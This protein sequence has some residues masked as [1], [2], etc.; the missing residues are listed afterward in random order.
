MKL[1]TE[2]GAFILKPETVEDC[3]ELLHLFCFGVEKSNSLSQ[4]SRI[5]GTL[6]ICLDIF[7]KNLKQIRDSD[8]WQGDGI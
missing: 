4:A 1:D 8:I 7:R 6:M 3:D 2:D 5:G